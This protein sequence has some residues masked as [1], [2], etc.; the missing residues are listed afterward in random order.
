MKIFL[1]MSKHLVPSIKDDDWREGVLPIE[2]SSALSAAIDFVH[3]YPDKAGVDALAYNESDKL[4]IWVKHPSGG[5]VTGF[6]VTIIAEYRITS[7]SENCYFWG[8]GNAP[9]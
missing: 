1:C 4:F 3:K 8:D 5:D 9:V 7:A 6:T 2:A